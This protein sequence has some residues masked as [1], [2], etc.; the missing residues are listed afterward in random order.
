M[1]LCVGR[2]SLSVPSWWILF[3]PS[4]SFPPSNSPRALRHWNPLMHHPDVSHHVWDNQLAVALSFPRLLLHHALSHNIGHLFRQA[5]QHGVLKELNFKV[6]YTWMVAPY[7]PIKSKLQF[8][9]LSR[10]QGEAALMNN[11]KFSMVHISQRRV[12]GRAMRV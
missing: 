5:S 7:S 12:A 4:S 6:P 9:G 11:H 3:L 2:K 1:P 8:P 10:A